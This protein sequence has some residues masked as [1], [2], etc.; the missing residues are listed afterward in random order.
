MTMPTR[1]V[2]DG[3]Q[4]ALNVTAATNYGTG[5]M[6]V[7]RVIVEVSAAAVSYV[8]D[9]A[10]TTQSAANTVLTIPAS[11]AVGTVYT[12]NW[13]CI[14]GLALVPGAGVTLA[15]SYSVGNQG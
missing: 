3:G 2:A 8:V 9:S 5:L 10:G 7:Y 6:T 11:T 12:L 4:T 14:Q 15:M 1:L 13:P